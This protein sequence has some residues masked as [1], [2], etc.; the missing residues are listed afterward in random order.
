MHNRRETKRARR[1]PRSTG[2]AK[3]HDDHAT[4]S[5]APRRRTYADRPYLPNARNH[6]SA[7]AVNTFD[8]FTT[9]NTGT[10][11]VEIPE[12]HKRRPIQ[13]KKI[14]FGFVMSIFAP[15]IFASLLLSIFHPDFSIEEEMAFWGIWA[16]SFGAGLYF[17][18]RTLFIW[19]RVLPAIGLTVFYLPVM[20]V[21]TL[22]YTI[23]FNCTVM[24][25]CF[26]IA[27]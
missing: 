21:G 6:D 24:N 1:S 17:F 16:L 11:T 12:N 20:S 7:S 18:A 15:I 19:R 2:T 13:G 27:C 14:A 4:G 26:M 9:W 25:T 8:R 5:V 3:R 10:E 23:L 22:I